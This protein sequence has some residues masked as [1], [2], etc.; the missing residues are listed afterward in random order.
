MLHCSGGRGIGESDFSLAGSETF[1]FFFFPERRT[2][3]DRTNLYDRQDR[4]GCWW[5]GM[6]RRDVLV[7][8]VEHEGADGGIAGYGVA[9]S[10]S[11]WPGSSSL[12]SSPSRTSLPLPS[13]PLPSALPF[14]FCLVWLV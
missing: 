6:T 13:C 1:F 7:G 12:S 10:S 11:L 3:R 4:E 9:R 5:W 14:Y 2:Q 8:L